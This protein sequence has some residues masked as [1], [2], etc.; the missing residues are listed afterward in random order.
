MIRTTEELLAL[1]D[2]LVDDK[3]AAWWDGFFAQRSRPISFF[4]DAPDENLVEWA[5]ENRLGRGRALELGC[6]KGR[7]AIFLA[8]HGFAVDAIDYSAEAIGWA[9]EAVSE[10][11]AEVSLHHCSIFDFVSP[12]RPYDLI[13]DCGLFHHLAPHRRHS[14]LA[15]VARHL[16]AGG[17]YGLVCFAPEGGSGLSDREVYEQRRLGGGLG[18][19]E[20]D[21][22]ELWD[23]PPFSVQALRR[24][25]QCDRGEP[26]FGEDFLWTLLAVRDPA[27]AHATW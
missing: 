27:A 2:D 5:Q 23:R 25:R 21:L 8:A 7:N 1:L 26:T 4:V 3:S 14:Y 11:G 6:G 22:R 20:E 24:M 17:R 18:Y 9:R 15:F 10:A 16:A 19:T 13:Y 12:G